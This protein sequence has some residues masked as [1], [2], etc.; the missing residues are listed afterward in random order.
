MLKIDVESGL[1]NEI[2]QLPTD[3]RTA[4]WRRRDDDKTTN[5]DLICVWLS[6]SATTRSPQLC[7]RVGDS[8]TGVV[9]VVV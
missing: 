3:G 9:D 8:G 1:E 7:R 4:E 2:G 6:F 5:L